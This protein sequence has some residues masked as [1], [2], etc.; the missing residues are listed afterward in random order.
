MLAGDRR[1]LLRDKL[2]PRASTSGLHIKKWSWS[3][4]D[5]VDI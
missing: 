5:L 2:K 4:P 1:V 3:S